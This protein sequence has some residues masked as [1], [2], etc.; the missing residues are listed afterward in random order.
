MEISLRALSSDYNLLLCWGFPDQEPRDVP[1]VWTGEGTRIS[2][3]LFRGNQ[4]WPYTPK[5]TY[6]IKKT[7][8][9][10]NPNFKDFSSLKKL[11]L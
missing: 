8:T 5:E 9:A 3:G 10:K 2:P 11:K 1:G 7:L 4:V 6:D